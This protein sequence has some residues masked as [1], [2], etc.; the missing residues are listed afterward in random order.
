VN[1]LINRV[2]SCP[3][4]D[5]ALSIAVL[6]VFISPATWA[7]ATCGCTLNAD[8][9]LGYGSTPGWRVSLE[10]D[11]IH[12]DELRSG[13]SSVGGVPDG[14]ELEHDTLNRYLTVGV[15]YS[16]NQDW[17]IDLRIPYVIRSHSTY[18]TYDSTEPLPPLSDSRSSSLGDL[19][20]IGSYQGLLE[21]HNLGVQLGLKFPTGQYGTDVNFRS[22]PAAGTP[23]DAS[24]NPGTGSTDI[25]VGAYYFQSVSRNFQFFANVQFQSAFTSKQDQPGNDFRPGNSTTVSFGLR[26]EENPTVIPQLQVNLLHKSVDQGALADVYDTAG[27]VAYLSP[28][29]NAQVGSRLNVYGFVQ[30]PVYSDLVG[31]QLFPRYTVSVGG[32]YAF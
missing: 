17:N 11:Y 29:L 20:L 3:T 2:V 10:Y 21:T 5:R 32:S 15:A 30:V 23:I 19:K 27:Y 9:A 8:A 13:T 7:C 28:G 1:K 14:Q 6:S 25:I 24:L 18:G 4:G 26:Y 16:P 31:Y 12:Q 22:G